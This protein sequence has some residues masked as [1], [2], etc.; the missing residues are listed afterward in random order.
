MK[1]EEI[2]ILKHISNTLDKILEKMSEPQSKVSQIF[3]ACATLVGVLGIIA[4]IDIILSWI[5]G[6]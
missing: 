3:N 6:L 5:K 2:A 4:I 1:Q